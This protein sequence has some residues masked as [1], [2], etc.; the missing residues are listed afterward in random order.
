MGGR[1]AGQSK[2]QSQSQLYSEIKGS[3][4]LKTTAKQTKHKIRMGRRWLNG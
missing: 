1:W 4:S 3:L 2:T